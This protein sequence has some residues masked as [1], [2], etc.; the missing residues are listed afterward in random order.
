MFQ[1]Q[2]LRKD[3]AARTV[4][5]NVTFVINDGEHVGL[6]GPN[7]TGKSTLLRLLT[8]QEPPDAGTISFAPASQTIGYL[9]QA[10]ATADGSNVRALIDA[11][12]APLRA[13]EAALEQAAAAL[14]TARDTTSAMQAYAEAT[15]Q[16]EARG[17][18]QAEQHIAEILGGLGLDSIDVERPLASLSGGQKT[19]LGLATLLLR[20]PDV[21]LLDEPTN[22]LD[23]AALQWLEDFV[24]GYPKAALIVS[25]DREFLDRTV[26]RTLYL[27]PTTTMVK[28]YTGGYSAFADARAHERDLH[29][30]TWQKQQEYITKVEGDIARLRGQALSVELS[31]TPRQPQVRR[32]AKKVAKKAKSRERKLERYLESDERVE[33]PRQSWGLKLDF[34]EPPA[35]GRALLRVAGV[36][37][38][39]PIIAGGE[40]SAP[41]LDDVSFEVGYGERLALVGANGAG[42]TTLLKLIAG[43]LQ[44][45]R[46]T[47]RLGSGVRLGVMAQEQETLDQTKTVLETAQRARPI[48][49][50]EARGFLHFFLFSGDSVFRPV[51]LCSLGERSRLQ[52][53]LL[54]LQGCNLLLLDEP[55]N[56]LDIEAREHFEQALEAF[57]GTVIAVA[58]D[59]AFLRSYPE[60]VIAVGGGGVRNYVGGYEQYLAALPV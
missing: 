14:A 40:T 43:A 12:L 35:A 36:S 1:V 60:R 11:A 50:T 10:S 23:V 24:R 16:F 21:L 39:Y 9:P 30:E 28:S 34:G 52:L 47:I 8:G 44:P 7:G 25:H 29:A 38:S 53:A 55:L 56:H 37:F 4:L 20:T 48:S 49:D 41:L 22:H 3:Y 15:A 17:G 27:D 32:I 33:K 5:S 13:A 2:H 57:D 31:T 51:G 58:H 54:V 26:S 45:D 46:G 19:R 42:K 59:R 18:Y 6:I